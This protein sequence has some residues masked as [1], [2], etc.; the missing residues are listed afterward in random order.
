VKIIQ[1]AN[2][3]KEYLKWKNKQ[4]NKKSPMLERIAGAR[5]SSR[6]QR[7]AFFIAIQR[8]FGSN[9]AK[10]MYWEGRGHQNSFHGGHW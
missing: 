3:K 7:V 9:L 8:H 6:G 1:D 2:G 10:N 4:T 5:V